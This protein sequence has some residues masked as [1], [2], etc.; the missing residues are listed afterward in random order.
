MKIYIPIKQHSQRVPNKNFRMFAGEPLW[1][2]TIQKFKNICDIFVDTDSNEIIE[3]S[4]LFGINAYM[5]PAH[6][7]GDDISVN[8]LIHN[9]IDSYCDDSFEV[10]AQIHVTSPFLNPSTLVDASNKI[11]AYY[12]SVVSC[13]I[14]RKRL[15]R[16]E[17]RHENIRFIPVNHNPL[18]LEQSQDLTPLYVE[19]SAFYIFTPSS[20]SKTNNRIGQNPLFVPL[21]AKES[22]DID[23]EEDWEK[24]LK[25]N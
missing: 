8:S 15:W 18:Y 22:M 7:H 20:F 17:N 5:R 9:F 16:P 1:I 10:L 2:R 13:D 19:N 4:E 6:L 25:I 23:T 11:S 24:C 3:Q 12:D 21:D 14:I